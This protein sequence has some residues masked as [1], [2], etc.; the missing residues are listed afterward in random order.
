MATGNAIDPIHQFIV[1]PLAQIRIGGIDASFTNASL[2]MVI[3]LTNLY[4][5][6]ANRRSQGA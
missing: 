6:I 3:V 1:A 5:Y 2:F 4:L